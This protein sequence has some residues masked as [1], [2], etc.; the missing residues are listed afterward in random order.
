MLLGQKLQLSVGHMGTKQSFDNNFSIG[1]KNDSQYKRVVLPIQSHNIV[2]RTSPIEK[3]HI[4][5]H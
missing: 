4:N 2:N 3:H 5:N 1:H